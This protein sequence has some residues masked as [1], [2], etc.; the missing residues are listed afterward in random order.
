MNVR[1]LGDRVLV[2]VIPRERKTTGGVILPDQAREVTDRGLVVAVGP[3]AS[4]DEK[5]TVNFRGEGGT[6]FERWLTRPVAV[7]VDEIVLFSP[8]AGSKVAVGND[9]FLLLREHDILGVLDGATAV[10][11]EEAGEW[12]LSDPVPTAV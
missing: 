1:P 9:D 5:Q 12:R 3:G 10:Y 11:D 4:L 6:S 2:K 7:A 8:Y